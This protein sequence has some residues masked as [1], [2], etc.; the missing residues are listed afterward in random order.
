MI[1]VAAPGETGRD[2]QQCPAVSFAFSGLD[3]ALHASC[4]FLSV[5]GT[6]SKTWLSLSGLEWVSYPHGLGRFF[7]FFQTY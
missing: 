1:E 3:A 7:A 6:A 4:T 2:S 5:F